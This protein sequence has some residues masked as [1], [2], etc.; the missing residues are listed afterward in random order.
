MSMSGIVEVE[1]VARSFGETHALKGVDL[2]VPEGRVVA[3]LGPNGAGKTTLVR[4]LATL[5]DPDAGTARIAG[6]DVVKQAMAVRRVIGLAG[7]YAAVDGTLTGRENLEMIG[8][9]S[10]L[11]KRLARERAAEVL[12]RLSLTDAADRQ[13]K[14]YSGGM[15]RRLDLAT[16]LIGHPRVLLL[17]E[18]TTGLD[19]RGR[20]ELWAYLRQL[21]GDGASLLLTTQYLEEADQLAHEIVV[22]DH[23]SI[24]AEGTPLQLKERLG[25]DVIDIAFADTELDCGAA[26]L[27]GFGS[28]PPSVDRINSRVTVP[29][30]DGADTLVEA[31]RRL[32]DAG[33]PMV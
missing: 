11:G 17:D 5:L 27:S 30:R 31:V 25:G 2:T 33:V 20:I 18:P 21:V 14:T 3:L 15:A 4:I 6:F 22:I 19:P 16:G 24:I 13:V 10:R 7:Q 8:R 28:D 1:G 23:G 9:L 32:D 12:D 26:A 29:A